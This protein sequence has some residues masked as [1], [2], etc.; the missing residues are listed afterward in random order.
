MAE[1]RM[2][3][4]TVYAGRADSQSL[5]ELNRLLDEGW[6]ISGIDPSLHRVPGVGNFKAFV[7]ELMKPPENSEQSNAPTGL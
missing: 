2:C 6:R 5:A 1:Q 7:V 3:L 4:M